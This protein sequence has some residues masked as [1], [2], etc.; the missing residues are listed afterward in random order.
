MVKQ[1]SKSDFQKSIFHVRYRGKT[2][3]VNRVKK[4]SLSVMPSK[5]NQIFKEM[6]EI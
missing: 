1:Y 6:K 4:D 2:E 5:V 3:I